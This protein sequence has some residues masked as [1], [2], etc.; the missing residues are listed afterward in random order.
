MRSPLALLRRR[1]LRFRVT[2]TF[3]TAAVMLAGVLSLATLVTVG[4]FLEDQRIRSSTRQTL[5][6][7]LFAREFLSTQPEPEE[8]VSRLQIRQRFDALVTSGDEWFAT[9]LELTPNSV[10]VGLRSLVTDEGLGYEIM[11]REPQRVLVFGTPLPPRGMDLYLFFPLDDIDQTMSVLGRALAVAGLA[12]VALMALVARRVTARILHPLTAVGDAAQRMAEG[13]LETR[14]ESESAD[15]LG[16]LAASFNRMGE[17]LRDMILHERRFVAAA[18]HELRT[19]LAA[20]QAAADVVAGY[21]ERLPAAGREAVDL[22]AEDLTALRELVDDLMEISELDSGRAAVRRERFELRTFVDTLLRRRRQ[23][24]AVDGPDLVIVTDKVRLERI[25]G[26]LVD[27]AYTHGEGRDVRISITELG[28]EFTVTVSDAG[29]GVPPEDEPLM[30]ERFYK[31][32]R[33]RSREQGGVGLGLAIAQENALL[34]GGSLTASIEAGHGAS[35]ILRLPASAP[36]EA[37]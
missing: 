9:G 26:N 2:V 35:F 10:P 7:L 29:P 22:I 5:F 31:P 14:V 36:P 30:F 37:P 18:S 4:R 3:V 8:L 33:S 28:S 27:N 21:R 15:E 11:L 12:V 16:Q 25:V 24:P 19:P 20:L 17:A 32:D 13:L 1:S 34:L 23:D 6:A